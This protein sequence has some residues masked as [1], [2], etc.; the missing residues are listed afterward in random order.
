MITYGKRKTGQEMERTK[1]RMIFFSSHDLV[2]NTLTFTPACYIPFP[3]HQDLLLRGKKRS[4]QSPSVCRKPTKN[5]WF[6]SKPQK[7][8]AICRGC[9]L[10]AD[11]L[12]SP[13]S[14]CLRLCLFFSF[15]LF[16]FILSSVQFPAFHILL[17]CCVSL[18]SGPR[19]WECVDLVVWNK[20]RAQSITLFCLFPPSISVV[21]FVLVLFLSVF[22]FLSFSQLGVCRFGRLE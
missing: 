4:I 9:Q 14:S 12:A 6:F 15:S 2:R 3:N 22:R 19:R 7:A 5:S 21:L 1:E 16:S 10:G 17:V 20:L 18:V 13:S 11:R 8:S